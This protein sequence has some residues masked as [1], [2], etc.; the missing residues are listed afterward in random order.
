MSPAPDVPE[1]LLIVDAQAW[2]GVAAVPGGALMRAKARFAEAKFAAACAKAGLELDPGV[3][4]HIVV[5]HDA[6]FRRVADSGWVGLAEGYMAGEWASPS[7]SMLV[8]A[9]VALLR[10]DYRPRTPGIAAGQLDPAGEIP[11]DLVQHF[12][13]DG[14]SGFAGHFATGVPTTE[15]VR[16]KFYA[17]RSGQAGASYFV[18]RT[19]FTAPLDAERGDLGDVQQRSV[20]MLLDAA[21]AGRGTHLLEYPSSGGA[22][23]LAAAKRGAT[24]DAWVADER[25]E[26]ALRDRLVYAGVGGAVHVEMVGQSWL[27]MP[28]RRGHYDCVVGVERLETLSAARKADYLAAMG[29]LVEPGGR[30]V[31]QTILRTPAFTPAAS[32]ALES[33]RAYIWPGLSFATPEG[34]ARTVDRRTSLR[35]VSETRA[36]EHLEA[37]LRLQREM[38]D[39]RFR[40]AAADGFDLV[41]RRLWQ[42][43]FALKEALARLG[44]I[45]L[46]QVTMVPRD[47][48][49]RR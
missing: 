44:M 49:G 45:D 39:G 36:P 17:P 10:V 43:Q 35:I 3:G 48:R 15:R 12:S 18:D 32:A 46:A 27:V 1:H 24:V 20:E 40:E 13:G 22:V 19:E 37:S 8:D 47:R 9:L 29:R 14:M 25:A 28:K 30:V 11:P 42:W 23:G 7:S 6:V 16:V 34:L 4:A 21:L 38:F 33:L 31:M 41:Y 5:E 26:A 2:P